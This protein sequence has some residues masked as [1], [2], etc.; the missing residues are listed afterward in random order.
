MVQGGGWK[1]G[2]SEDPGCTSLPCEVPAMQQI[3]YGIEFISGMQ[4]G[5]GWG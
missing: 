4:R 3:Q 5:V 1:G 2:A